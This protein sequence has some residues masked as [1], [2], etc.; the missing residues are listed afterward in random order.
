MRLYW[1]LKKN[2]I[3]NFL[4]NMENEKF[5]LLNESL[6]AIHKRS[7]NLLILK[8]EA[9][10]G[11]SK[12]TLDFLK[13]NNVDF[14]YFSSYSTPLAFYNLIY[15]NRDKEVLVFD[16]IE[17][18][19]DLKIIAMLKS[20]CWSPD[21]N[22]REVCYFSTAE[23]LDKKGLPDRFETDARIILIFNNNLRGFEPVINRGI[24]LDFNFNFKEKMGIF[25]E[26]KQ[27]ASLDSEVLEWVKLNCN[28]ST[29]NLSLRSLVILSNLKKDGFDFKL[30][31]KEILKGD[32]EI[33]ALLDLCQ[34]AISVND[35]CEQ[36]IKRTGK[37]R[38]SFFRLKKK[39]NL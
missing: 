11:K 28:E 12:T 9:G 30:F 3:Y 23:F 16:D 20:L 35:S 19:S 2:S 17:G 24:C 5:I 29:E 38:R 33:K 1:N 10:T 37:S 26:M 18:I 13:K 21:N 14:S 34:S 32:D 4:F 25:E 22:K 7:I 15:E 6:K 31:A 27:K 36:W 8:G 39:L